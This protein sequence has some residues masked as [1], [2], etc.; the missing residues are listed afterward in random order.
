MKVLSD[1][2][3]TEMDEDNI[4]NVCLLIGHD[5][6]A[7][8]KIRAFE[9]MTEETGARVNIVVKATKPRR[10]N[11]KNRDGS[12]I[13]EFSKN[14]LAPLQSRLAYDPKVSTPLSEV[15][16]LSKAEWKECELESV[17]DNCYEVPSDTVEYI[18]DNCD[19]VVQFAV[20]ILKGDI[21]TAP[22]YGVLGYHL[23]DIREYRGSYVTLWM[24]L[25]NVQYAGVTLQQLTPELDAGRVISI[26]EADLT[27]VRSWPETRERLYATAEGMMAEGIK[28]L[29][30]SNFNPET[31]PEE[32]LGPLYHSSDINI[33]TK[34]RLLTST[35]RRKFI[36]DP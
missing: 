11:S 32:E 27:G 8:W 36:S 4:R 21:L 15:D 28:K 23:G 1:S 19:V 35:L 33:K 20:G 6:L 10:D 9:R 34:I 14:L 31:L 25:D 18:R 16:Y 26:K 13:N 22:E 17:S 7:N 5:R 3:K 12:L 2:E 29:S 30:D 24:F